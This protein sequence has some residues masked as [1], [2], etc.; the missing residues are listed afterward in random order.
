MTRK[1]NMFKGITLPMQCKEGA[2]SIVDSV[3][4]NGDRSVVTLANPLKQGDAVALVGEMLVEKA[5]G[6]NGA[7]FG[8]VGDHPEYDNDP[9]TNYTAAQAITNGVLRRAGIE[10]VYNDVRTVPAKASEA[11]KAGMFVEFSS[12]GFKKTASSG[13]TESNC[14]ALTDQTSAN[15]IVIA[16]K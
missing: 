2:V 12:S 10:T 8:F 4:V 9:R 16:I 1:I 13:T 3:S 11:I 7:V 6:T 14:L 15:E 5:D